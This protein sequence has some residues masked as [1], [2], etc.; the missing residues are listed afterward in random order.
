MVDKYPQG[1]YLHFNKGVLRP[2][3]VTWKNYFWAEGTPFLSKYLSTTTALWAAE[4]C[5]GFTSYRTLLKYNSPGSFHFSPS[6]KTPT[7]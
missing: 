3:I 6:S 1:I 7:S 5:S 2:G 4:I